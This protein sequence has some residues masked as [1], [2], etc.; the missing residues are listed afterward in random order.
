M[1]VRDLLLVIHH[2]FMSLGV[3]EIRRRGVQDEKSMRMV[4]TIVYE[5]CKVVVSPLFPPLPRPPT[6]LPAPKPIFE[7]LSRLY[8]LCNGSF[9]KTNNTRAIESQML[10]AHWL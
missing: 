4:K 5:L 8:L 7:G 9:V 3:D 10:P 6:P 1:D 2:Y